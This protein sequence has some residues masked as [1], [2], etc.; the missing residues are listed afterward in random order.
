MHL[1]ILMNLLFKTYYSH[2]KKKNTSKIPTVDAVG[3]PSVQRYY[4]RQSDY[5]T[6]DQFT[7]VTNCTDGQ[8]SVPTILDDFTDGILFFCGMSAADAPLLS[9]TNT[10]MFLADTIFYAKL[11][12]RQNQRLSFRR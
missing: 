8:P 2:K 12:R 5:M 10:M 6:I 7:S 4:R 11:Y 3:V 1:K 9:E